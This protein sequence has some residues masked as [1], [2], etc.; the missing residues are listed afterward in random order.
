MKT[1]ITISLLITAF[2]AA[3]Y[4]MEQD[5]SNTNL[6]HNLPFELKQLVISFV[7]STG[8]LGTFKTMAQVSK[9]FQALIRHEYS[10]TNFVK[11]C[12]QHDCISKYIFAAVDH[13]DLSLVKAF[14]KAGVDV[15]LTRENSQS[16]LMIAAE[17]GHY[18]LVRFL[19][20]KNA[21][22]N[23][24]TCQENNAEGF[25][26]LTY[27]AKNGHITIVEFL[28]AQNATVNPT[29][30]EHIKIIDHI[31]E[32]I[33]SETGYDGYTPLLFAAENGHTKIVKRLI[34]H[35]AD[36]YA[37]DTSFCW[38]PLIRAAKAGHIE[39]VKILAKH[40]DPAVC[41][42][43]RLHHIFSNSEEALIIAAQEKHYAIVSLLKNYCSPSLLLRAAVRAGYWQLVQE[44]VDEGADVNL[45]DR[46]HNTALMY[47][48]YN[49]HYDIA[50]QLLEHGADVNAQNGFDFSPL[51]FAIAKGHKDIVQ[52]LLKHGARTHIV[53]NRDMVNIATSTHC[54]AMNLTSLRFDLFT[55]GKTFTPVDMAEHLNYHEIKELLLEHNKS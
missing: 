12:Q 20:D 44:L 36:I 31:K 34:A 39:T 48:A 15:N 35:G 16:L 18:D 28:L 43:T 37:Q 14:L 54:I 9:E 17:R 24:E 22:V 38:T 42:T 32:E 51:F 4:P 11:Q 1:E 10:L 45:K 30:I 19:V 7:P 8:A 2:I 21:R 46:R 33:R 6:W 25:T 49:N 29:I 13:N 23:A 26:A 41:V 53:A 40:D 3:S 5:D 50:Q 52:L 27:A 47:A 55:I